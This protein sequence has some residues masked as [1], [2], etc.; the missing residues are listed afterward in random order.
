M[1]PAATRDAI[2]E[3]AVD[4]AST[5]G[6]GA[7]IRLKQRGIDDFVVLE[8]RS[9]VGGTW[10]DNTYPGCQCDI[11]SNL[12]SFS[13]APNPNWSRTFPTQPEI[14]D[15]LREC[16]QRFG[17]TP[18][19]RFDTDVTEAAW[20][21]EAGRWRLQT[22]E[23][24][25]TASIVIAAPG[26]LS[27]PAVPDLPGLDSFQGPAFHTARWDHDQDLAGKRVAV[28]GTGAS[29][30]QVVPHIQPEV[31]QLHVFQRTPPWIVPHP[32][33]PVSD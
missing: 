2:L 19:I 33:R 5:E 17:I 6:L 9:D 21:G 13:F 8:R 3:R 29:S 11:P 23:G 25:L 7:A 32:D 12:Y 27:E 30:I 22:T 10:Y 4:L 28:V 16:A 26:G 14:W 18:H 20:D 31:E 24:P 1:S 15:Y